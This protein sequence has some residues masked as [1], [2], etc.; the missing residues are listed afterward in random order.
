MQPPKLNEVGNKRV[1]GKE[2]DYALA[3]QTGKGHNDALLQRFILGKHLR[4]ENAMYCIYDENRSTIN[5]KKPEGWPPS[6]RIPTPPDAHLYWPHLEHEEWGRTKVSSYWFW[7]FMRNTKR[8]VEVA[9]QKKIDW[10]FIDHAYLYHQRHS[11][12]EKYGDFRN[13][14]FRVCKNNYVINKITDTNDHRYLELKARFAK[15]NELEILNWK[16]GGKHIVVFPPSWWLCKNLG[17]RAED[18]LQDTIDELKKHTDREIRVRVKK[19]GGQYNPVPLHED[20]KDCHA[21]VSYQS[22]A[23]AK[24]IIKGVPSFTITDKYSAAIPMSQTDLSKIE[25]PIY[26]DNRYEWLCNLANHQ[27]YANEIQSGYAERYLNE[28]DA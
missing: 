21:V 28:Q 10:F 23:A 4:K 6:R 15:D 11:M 18:V 26:P 22:S 1:F 13:C 2:K 20:L 24:A 14:L 5:F 8:I 16:K 27:F 19:I 3:F 7:G 17:M 9:E 25:T 12:F